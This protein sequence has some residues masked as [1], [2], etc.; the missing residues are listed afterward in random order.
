M[1]NTLR[2]YHLGCGERLQAYS[3]LAMSMHK[4]TL[5]DAGHA[6]RPLPLKHKKAE[7]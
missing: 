4:L 7:H 5:K 1:F 3:S 6:K 2:R